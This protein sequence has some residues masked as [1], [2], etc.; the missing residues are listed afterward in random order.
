MSMEE[1]RLGGGVNGGLIV[2]RYATKEMRLDGAAPA[3]AG[4]FGTVFFVADAA[5]ELVSVTERHATAG[6]DGSAVTAM[7]KKVPSGTAAGSGTDM[8]SAGINLK[9]TANTNQSGSLSATAANTRLAA[10]DG[11]AVVLTG[12]P[13]ALAGVCVETVWK[14]I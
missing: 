1:V 12:T 8:L 3:T 13:T 4:N 6:S 5:Y 9:A 14:R 10:G 11:V 2:P 7:L